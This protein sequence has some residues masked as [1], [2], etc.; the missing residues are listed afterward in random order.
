M[1]Q[2]LLLGSIAALSLVSNPAIAQDPDEIIYVTAARVPILSDDATTSIT[3]LDAAVLEARGPLFLADILRATP[4]LAISRSGPTGSLT[5]I[6]ARGSEANH[7]LL[8]IDG[9]EAAS[10]FTGE[11]DVSNL[12]FDDLGSI[13]IA[14]GEQSALWGADAIGGVIAL[15]TRRPN[16]GAEWALRGEAGS[17]G[18]ARLTGRYGHGF[19]A[20]SITLSG[21]YYTTDG[22]DASGLDGETE[23]YRNQTIGATGHYELSETW[24]IEGVARWIGFD[25]NADSD[26]DFDGRLDDVDRA[27]QGD[28]Y[29]T[30]L[31]LHGVTEFGGLMLEHRANLRLTD[32]AARNLADGVQSG[33]TLGQR[34][35]ADYQLTARWESGMASH[36][37]TG[38]VE[39]EQDEIK[40]DAGPG[41]LANQ[42]REVD[43][44][45]LAVD[46]GL[47]Y[48]RF[49]VT[50]SVRQENN[51]LF[52]DAMTWRVGAAYALDAIQARTWISAGEG[53]KNPGLFELF[54]FF[55]DFFVGNPDLQPERSAGWEIGFQQE[56]HQGQASW[57]IT[58]F[59]SE[60]DDEI[61]T[62]FGVFPFTARNA[63]AT[64]TRRGVE[65]EGRT[66][67][68]DTLSAFG[69]AAWMQSEEDGIAEIRRPERLAS[70]T[71][72]WQP[73]GDWS[74]SLS[75]D[76]T[77]EQTDTD[78]GTFQTVTLDAYTLVSGQ[79]RWQAGPGAELYLR[80]EN[81]L[82]ED[83]QDVF[84]YST[85]GRGLYLGL[86]L[87]NDG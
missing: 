15:S 65:L 8:L 44:L 72:D 31:G 63:G 20:G 41:N 53:V 7:V 74:A 66:R 48:R 39:S 64:S 32:E 5:Q 9:I 13:E 70:L 11:A 51:D 86:R 77:G 4:G 18:T 58:Y 27:R 71:L 67:L 75:A 22:I 68:T 12:L 46:Y 60:L 82:D 76:Y 80:G 35:M 26:T 25:G 56:V 14:R 43:M 73:Q 50:A 61:F 33:R 17:F 47:V 79:L 42:T 10:P 34:R 87:R 52:D 49:D 55:P 78:F 69:S 29:L 83:Y 38:L 19:E 28:Q 84:G 40:N 81:L 37:L 23:S 54:G 16:D 2:T 6:R 62:D 57:A 21:G 3:R 30:R 45:A 85:P 1:K 59:D 24:Q 36:R